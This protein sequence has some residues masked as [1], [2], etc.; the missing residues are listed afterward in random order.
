MRDSTLTDSR[1]LTTN[2]EQ[3]FFQIV[4]NALLYRQDPKT[5]IIRADLCYH[6][7]KETR[8]VKCF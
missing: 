1:I 8:K 2:S 4:F 7:N 6:F 3:S 5:P